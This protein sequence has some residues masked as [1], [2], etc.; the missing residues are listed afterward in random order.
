VAEVAAATTILEDKDVDPLEVDA[1][2]MEA[3]RVPLKGPQQCRHCGRSN[4]I[5][6]K[7]WEKFGRLEWAQLADFDP[8][9]R[10]IFL[11]S[12]HPLILAL[13]RLYYRKRSMI[14]SA[15]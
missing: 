7:C 14:N 11:R 4:H 3:D 8:P 2:L 1:V 9:A 10:V 5:S 6:E 15:R 13:P 12:F